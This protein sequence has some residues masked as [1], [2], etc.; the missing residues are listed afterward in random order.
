MTCR[1]LNFELRNYSANYEYHLRVPTKLVVPTYST[2]DLVVANFLT[3]KCIASSPAFYRQHQRYFSNKLHLRKYG[4]TQSLKT[5][6]WSVCLKTMRLFV[7][8]LTGIQSVWPARQALCLFATFNKQK[9]KR[10][11]F[12]TWRM[13][14]NTKGQPNQLNFL[15][16]LLVISF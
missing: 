13:P 6:S 16:G 14:S 9:M 7:A 3:C 10:L 1:C 2:P 5:A 12:C 4:T 8:A 15:F 11:V